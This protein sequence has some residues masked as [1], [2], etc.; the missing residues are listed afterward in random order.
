MRT[1]TLDLFLYSFAEPSALWFATL[2]LVPLILFLLERRHARI[3][4]WPAMRF[5]L[6]DVRRRTRWMRFTELLLLATR[7]LVI[8]GIALVFARPAAELQRPATAAR[9]GGVAGVVFLIDNSFS[10]A[11]REEGRSLLDRARAAAIDVI[12]TLEAGDEVHIVTLA[13]EA[14][15]VA[16]AAIRD[17][18][19]AIATLEEVRLEGGRADV[20]AG[21]DLAAELLAE[22]TAD[23][24]RVII[25]SDLQRHAW[26]LAEDA[27]WRFV[28]ERLAVQPAPSI[29]VLAL[30]QPG[31][32]PANAAVVSLEVSRPVVGTDRAVDIAATVS[33]SGGEAAVEV[34]LLDDGREI[35]SR[36][37]APAAAR[38]A[39]VR[40]SHR[41]L[42]P[43]T[44]R[45]ELAV[46]GDALA[47]DDVRRLVI[48]VAER[49]PVLILE[50]DGAGGGPGEIADL[51]L[52][53]RAGE[54][55]TPDVL[56]EPRTIAARDAFGS[57]ALAAL[58]RGESLAGGPHV[59]V[60]AD[61]PRLD[62]RTVTAIESFVS[63]GGGLLV[64]LGPR[65][66][67]DA[68]NELFHRGGRG[69]LPVLL[70]GR[71]S[72]V[73][74]P[75]E[76]RVGHPALRPLTAENRAELESLEAATW[77]SCEAA[78][79]AT[80][81]ATLQGGA[82]FIVESRHGAG[83]VVV[84]ATAPARDDDIARRPILVPLLHGLVEHL[85]GGGG[86]R[87]NVL[88][89]EDIIVQLAAAGEVGAEDLNV[90]L[91]APDGSL[92]ALEVADD[93]RVVATARVP[94]FHVVHIRAGDRERSVTFAANLPAEESALDALVEEEVEKIRGV[95]GFT[96]TH[97]TRSLDGDA[98]ETRRELWP[99][100]LAAVLALALVETF[101]QRRLIGSALGG[102][103]AR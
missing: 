96:V 76:F 77:V 82:P 36:S 17:P 25:P 18:A 31:A 61:V 59:V 39:G 22:T 86:P 55:V 74:S 33:A 24:T 5:F 64:L 2:A 71:G 56:F 62:E 26:Q 43:G 16:P 66:D 29:E 93:G 28:L 14:R 63:R 9:G 48:E 81:L 72:G 70:R 4:D 35:V 103:D 10:M 68:W 54:E 1:V 23:T 89:G 94:G 45:V 97:D 57:G 58:A 34:T 80:V 85:A 19:A 47:E 15:A 100:F 40:F 101:L 73:A 99:R 30:R 3:I 7:M 11:W 69:A 95:L 8:A 102:S 32:T 65:V 75:R 67:V 21:L 52:A 79:D 60:L 53:P 91:E 90:A 46:D 27:R 51:A 88:L 44:H 38:D 92:A 6:R 50:G 13:G 98:V 87:R 49:V 84:M 37:I 41:F 42:S 12:D 20:I 83:R 78:P